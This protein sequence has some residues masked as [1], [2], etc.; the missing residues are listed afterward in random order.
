MIKL[1]LRVVLLSLTLLL[2]LAGSL[3][4]NR[5]GAQRPP[6]GPPEGDCYS[7][8]GGPIVCRHGPVGQRCWAESPY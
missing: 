2:T 5:A 1:I 3:N 8:L 6:L 7:C 4:L